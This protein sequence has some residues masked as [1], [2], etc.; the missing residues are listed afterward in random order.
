M[1][2]IFENKENH[3]I[4]WRKRVIK[5]AIAEE[6]EFERIYDRENQWR[7][8]GIIEIMTRN[9]NVD[10]FVKEKEAEI[11]ELRKEVQRLK[12]LL[13]DHDYVAMDDKGWYCKICEKMT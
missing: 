11:E 9:P 4:K 10:S 13:C 3:Y 5:E 2:E 7:T 12:Q 6:S 8:W 1:D